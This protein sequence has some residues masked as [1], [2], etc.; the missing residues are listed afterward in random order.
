MTE[1]P[2]FLLERWSAVEREW[3]WT[4]LDGGIESTSERQDSAEC[5]Q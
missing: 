1:S 3:K 2:K 4:S 5:S